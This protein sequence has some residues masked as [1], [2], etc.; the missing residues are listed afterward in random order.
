MTTF[1]TQGVFARALDIPRSAASKAVTRDYPLPFADKIASVRKAATQA[2]EPWSRVASSPVLLAENE[3]KENEAGGG[4]TEPEPV[5]EIETAPRAFAAPPEVRILCYAHHLHYLR[6][7]RD[8]VSGKRE[9]KRR[10]TDDLN[11]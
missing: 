11:G 10:S 1:L 7:S 4:Q 3:N 6:Q 2:L 5:V 9:K 8:W